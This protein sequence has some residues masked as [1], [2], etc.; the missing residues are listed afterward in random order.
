MCLHKQY[1]CHSIQRCTLY[2]ILMIIDTECIC[3]YRHISCRFSIQG[4]RSKLFLDVADTLQHTATRCNNYYTAIHCWNCN[5]LQQAPRSK[6]SYGVALPTCRC[7]PC[8]LHMRAKTCSCVWLDSLLCVACLPDMYH[9]LFHIV[10][11]FGWHIG[12]AL[13]VC[14]CL[15]LFVSLY[16]SFSLSLS[17]YLFLSLCWFAC[18]VCMFVCLSVCLFVCLSDCLTACLAVGSSITVYHT[19][20]HTCLLHTHTR[21]PNS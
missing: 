6:L 14:L 8:V 17:L 16:L 12:F 1:V 7:V 11:P 10:T 21:S 15:H 5:T 2:F 3:I 13:S 19:V 4:P 20:Y 18:F 9:L